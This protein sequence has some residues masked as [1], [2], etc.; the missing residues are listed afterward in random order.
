MLKKNSSIEPSV[1]TLDLE[2]LRTLAALQ[3]LGSLDRVAQHVGRTASAVSVQLRLL[4]ARCGRPLF[5]K[6]GRRLMLN[7]AGETVLGYGR[8]MLQLNDHLLQQLQ[9][10]AHPVGIRLGVPQDVA[11]KAL[12]RVL[13]KFGRAHPEVDLRVTVGGNAELAEQFAR[14]ALDLAVTFEPDTGSGGEL[15]GRV[16]LRWLASLELRWDGDTP[17]PLVMFEPPCVFR[18]AA[19]ESLDRAGFPWRPAFTSPS[20]SGLWAAVSAGLGVTVRSELGV[21]SG[22]VRVPD[23]SMPPLPPLGL[24]LHGVSGPSALEALRAALREVLQPAVSE[25]APAERPSARRSTRKRAP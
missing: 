15:I 22:I 12:A 4:E 24:W 6:V 10:D 1:P 18:R 25:L 11:E 2:H 23:D 14:G 21:P 19:L 7:T 3:D 17:L 13:A 20:L 9:G 5:R 16:P 8:R